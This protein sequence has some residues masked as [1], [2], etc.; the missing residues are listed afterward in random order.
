M[1]QNRFAYRTVL[2]ATVLLTVLVSSALNAE[3]VGNSGLDEEGRSRLPRS[4]ESNSDHF[5]SFGRLL[6]SSGCC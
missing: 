6:Y 1:L 4:S 2:Q 3:N 5:R